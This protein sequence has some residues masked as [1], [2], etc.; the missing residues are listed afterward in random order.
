[1]VRDPQYHDVLGQKRK[2]ESVVIGET[3]YDDTAIKMTTEM[4]QPKLDVSAN[5]RPSSRIEPKALF[6]S[7][8][9]ES[10]AT[11]R[12]NGKPR[13]ALLLKRT[14]TLLICLA[15]PLVRPSESQLWKT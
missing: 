5:A 3:E 11:L 14:T 15:L 4:K 7:G 8:L 13:N 2:Y 1:M 9:G 6:L 12:M 10:R